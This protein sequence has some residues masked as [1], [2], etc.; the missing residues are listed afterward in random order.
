LFDTDGNGIKNDDQDFTTT[1][2]GRW[3]TP[4]YT[5]YGKIVVKLTVVDIYGNSH[6]KTQEIKFNPQE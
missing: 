6:T 3:T 4:F 1:F 5:S 2:P